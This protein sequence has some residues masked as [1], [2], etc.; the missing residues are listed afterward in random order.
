M[1]LRETLDKIRSTGVPPNEEATKFQIIAP[2]LSDLG[3]DPFGTN[4]LY[5]HSVGG[6]G[7]LVDIALQGPRDLV[8]LI[9]AKAPGIDLKKHV[10]QVLRY[11]HYEGVDICVLTNGLEWWL[12]LPLDRGAP[13]KRRFTTLH[14]KDDPVEQL[15]NDL[16]TFLGEKNLVDGQAQKRAKQVLKASRQAAFLGTQIPEVW[17]AMLN[18]PDDDLVELV[19]QRVYEKIN[20]RPDPTQ[21]ASVLLG[22]PV[23]PVVPTKPVTPDPPQPLPQPTP[24]TK[25]K[26]K[27]KTKPTGFRLWGRSYRI[28]FLNEILVQVGEA[29]YQRYGSEF[30]N[31]LLALRGHKRVYAS[32]NPDDLSAPHQISS[33][34]IFLDTKLN[35]K[36]TLKRVNLLL[37]LVKCP[38]SD[39]EIL[40]E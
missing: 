39:L 40:Y 12:Y 14:I 32:R 16:E 2:I 15:A 3:W 29:L 30:V 8:A 27:T 38:P 4:V 11:A 37:S 6:E 26:I 23:P 13:D 34:G 18:D 24:T 7:G 19:R 5:E 17:K 22:S 21:V 28:K 1:A 33:S 9:E 36:D 10:S 25:T 35:K 31:P 20:L